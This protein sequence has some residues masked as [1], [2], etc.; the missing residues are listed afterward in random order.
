MLDEDDQSWMDLINK[1]KKTHGSSVVK[2]KSP[3]QCWHC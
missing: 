3:E 2:D 1:D